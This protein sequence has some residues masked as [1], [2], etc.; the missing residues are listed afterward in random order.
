MHCGRQRSAPSNVSRG[1][2]ERMSAASTFR[3]CPRARQPVPSD[4]SPGGRKCGG[5]GPAAPSPTIGLTRRASDMNLAPP[6]AQLPPS[7]AISAPL[8]CDDAPDSNQEQSAATSAR[9]GRR[10][11][12]APPGRWRGETALEPRP[13]S[14]FRYSPGRP[15]SRASRAH[16][17]PGLPCG[18]VPPPRSLTLPA[19]A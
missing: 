15:R 7:T 2:L 14:G 11:G 1:R 16:Q 5:D 3:R 10:D 12:A 17:A 9:V 13:S 18:S 8:T 4:Y 19:A 6:C